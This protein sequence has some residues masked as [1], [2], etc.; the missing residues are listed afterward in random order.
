VAATPQERRVSGYSIHR[1]GESGAL[2]GTKANHA[3][4]LAR[5]V[6]GAPQVSRVAGGADAVADEA[7]GAAAESVAD[8]VAIAVAGTAL[9]VVAGTALGAVADATSADCEVADTGT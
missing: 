7:L 5:G 8:A 6:H 3:G 9:G 4:A 1:P 2:A